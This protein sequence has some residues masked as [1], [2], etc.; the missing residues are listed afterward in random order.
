MT[1][2]GMQGFLGKWHKTSWRDRVLLCEAMI[3]LAS[4]RIA[5]GVLPFQTVCRAAGRIRVNRPVENE[6][7]A[8]IV[9]QVRWAIHACARRA[10]F[11]AVCVQQGL[12]A[13]TMLRRRGVPSLLYFGAALDRVRGLEAHVWVRDGESDVVGCEESYRFA[14]LAR[15][16]VNST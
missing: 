5:V 15:F 7:R 1:W 14:I 2:L 6:A 9:R 13:Q 8:V 4:A 3:A 10:P 12:A 11:R 16:P